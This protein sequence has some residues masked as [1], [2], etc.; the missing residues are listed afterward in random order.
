MPTVVFDKSLNFDREK[1]LKI[2]KENN[3]DGRVFFY[4]LSSLP[5]FD[6]RKENQVSY[7]IFEKAINLPSYHEMTNEDIKIVCNILMGRYL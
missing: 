7:G 4:P 3:I 6:E 5:M 2:F 1:L